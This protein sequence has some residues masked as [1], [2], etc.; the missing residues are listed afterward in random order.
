ML[1]SSLDVFERPATAFKINLI[2]KKA[3]TFPVQLIPSRTL[4]HRQ[5]PENFRNRRRTPLALVSASA[6][7]CTGPSCEKEGE[8]ESPNL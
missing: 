7:E 3:D 8:C 4:L 6:R 1:S 2:D 5:V